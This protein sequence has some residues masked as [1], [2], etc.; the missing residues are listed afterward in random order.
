MTEAHEDEGAPEVDARQRR[1]TRLAKVIAALLIASAGCC[2]AALIGGGVMLSDQQVSADVDAPQRPRLLTRA[3]VRAV[4]RADAPATDDAAHETWATVVRP[5][6][7]V[8]FK[9][10][11]A[12]E[13]DPS[14]VK[15]IHSTVYLTESAEDAAALYALQSQMLPVMLKGIS[16]AGLELIPKDHSDQVKLGDASTLAVLTD[17]SGAPRGNMVLARSGKAV[18]TLLIEGAG[19]LPSADPKRPGLTPAMRDVYAA[20]LKAA[21]APYP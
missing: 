4:M 3:S 1:N 15:S 20:Q 5:A 17:A 21:T 8:M 14:G 18:T 19:W 2:A 7:H 10:D 6:Q 13:D 16:K 11:Y 12:R 9:Y